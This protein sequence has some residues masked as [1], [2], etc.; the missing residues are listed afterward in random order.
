MGCD[1]YW[2][3]FRVLEVQRSLG[4]VL[5]CVSVSRVSVKKAYVTF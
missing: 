4:K 2:H 5:V 3:I 1:N